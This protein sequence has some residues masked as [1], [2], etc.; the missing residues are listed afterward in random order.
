MTNN[1]INDSFTYKSPSQLWTSD[2]S[3][4]LIQVLIKQSV[5]KIDNLRQ[6]SG[7]ILHRVIHMT[8]PSVPF[9]PER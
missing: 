5:E 6:V 7:E 3:L 1:P 2:M 8:G 4:R 9:I